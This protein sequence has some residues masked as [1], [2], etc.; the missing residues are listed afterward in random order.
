MKK[1]TKTG[2]A[3]STSQFSGWDGLSKSKMEFC[4]CDEIPRKVKKSVIKALEERNTEDARKMAN[5]LKSIEA[6]DQPNERGESH[7]R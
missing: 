4:Y 5:L 3:D 6:K 2:R 7:G 1:D